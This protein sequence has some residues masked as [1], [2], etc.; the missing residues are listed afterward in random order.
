MG[1]LEEIMDG[2]TDLVFEYVAEGNSAERRRCIA[3]LP[4]ETKRRFNCCWMPA[5]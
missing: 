2:R 1:K 3:P 5:R 4:L